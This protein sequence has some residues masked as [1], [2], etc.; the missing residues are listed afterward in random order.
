MIRQESPNF[1]ASRFAPNPLEVTYWID[2]TTNPNGGT[3]RVWNGTSWQLIDSTEDPEVFDRIYDLEQN[4]VDKVEGKGL[5]TNDYTTA[6]KEKLADL[7]N[8]SLPAATTDSIGGIRKGVA[9]N[10]LATDAEL[11]AVITK[12]NELLSSLRTAKVID[13]P[14]A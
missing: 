9:V 3:I 14:A 13:T 8:Y 1:K 12:I 7:S 5:S 2:L 6:E 10:N 4:K 11:A